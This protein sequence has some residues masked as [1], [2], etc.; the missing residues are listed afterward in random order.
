MVNNNKILSNNFTSNEF[1]QR[2]KKNLIHALQKKCDH[3]DPL[4]D[5]PFAHY[6][7]GCTCRRK[8]DW[9]FCKGAAVNCSRPQA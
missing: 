7:E 8:V 2:L 9:V 6:F 5:E 4:E 1:I 3:G